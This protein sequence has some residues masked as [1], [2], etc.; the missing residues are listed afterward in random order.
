M[1]VGCDGHFSLEKNFVGVDSL[2]LVRLINV[3]LLR[4]LKSNSLILFINIQYDHI[5]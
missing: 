1:T 3:Y 5:F 4:L 2:K